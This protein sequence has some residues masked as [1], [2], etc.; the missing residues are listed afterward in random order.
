MRHRGHSSFPGQYLE[1][2]SVIHRLP[3]TAK[4]ILAGS[5]AVAALFAPTHRVTI[6]LVLL[7]TGIYAAARLGWR[8][9]GQ[10][11]IV[12]LLQA[13][14]VLA[15]FFWRDGVA[16][17]SAAAMVSARL[18][19]VSLP[20]LW[21]Q[22]TTRITDLS[23][24]LSRALPQHLAFVLAMSLRFLPLIAREAREIYGRQ[25]LRGARIQPRDLLNP[26]HWREASHCMAIPL[27]MRTLHLADQVAVAA[28][29]RGVGESAATLRAN[30]YVDVAR[31]SLR[32]AAHD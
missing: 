16:G 3:A 32:R 30:Q 8:A 28:K 7:C 23:R 9:F 19:L 20:G 31:K 12:V 2:T 4:M 6:G 17:L 14:L 1:R 13:P 5:I 26:M 11:G 15:I 29:Q 10:D 22:R 24:T 21:L 27:L 18:A 25:Q